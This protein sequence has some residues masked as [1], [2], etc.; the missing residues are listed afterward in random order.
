MADPNLGNAGNSVM[1]I[2]TK[3]GTDIQARIPEMLDYFKE[4][5][6]VYQGGHWQKLLLTPLK[7][8]YFSEIQVDSFNQGNKTFLLILGSVSLLILLFAIINYIDLTVA[9]TPIRWIVFRNK[10]LDCCYLFIYIRKRIFKPFSMIH[11]IHL[12][13]VF[14]QIHLIKQFQIDCCV[15]AFVFRIFFH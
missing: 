7:E 5:Y 11:R 15:C 8:V 1:F 12:F 3:E 10:R 9:Q 2:L 6:W 14:C 13:N 4:F